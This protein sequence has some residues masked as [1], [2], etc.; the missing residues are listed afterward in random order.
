MRKAYQRV[1][2]F[3]EEKGVNRRVAALAL[4]IERIDQVYAERGIFP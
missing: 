3:A 2:E 1:R 4:A